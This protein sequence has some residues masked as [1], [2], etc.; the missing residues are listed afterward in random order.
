MFQHRLTFDFILTS[1]QDTLPAQNLSLNWDTSRFFIYRWFYII[2]TGV[3]KNSELG[4]KRRLLI[5]AGGGK[6]ILHNNLHILTAAGGLQVTE[7]WR[8][9]RD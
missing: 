6:D 8:Y 1:Q 7:E 9:S 4:L 2:F 5:G 3:E